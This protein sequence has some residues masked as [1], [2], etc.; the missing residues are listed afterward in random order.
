MLLN[1]F[2]PAKEAIVDQRFKDQLNDLNIIADSTANIQMTEYS[3]NQISYQYQA[4]T[5][6]LAVFSEVYYQPG[7]NAYIDGKPAKHFRANYVLRAMKLP[8]GNH[9]VEFKF[10]PKGYFVGE[11]ISLTSMILFFVVAIGAIVFG[12]KN[13]EKENE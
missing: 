3:P 13:L 12:I 10:E 7:W 1:G 2:D 8:V 9:K 5:E 4:K 6:Q 11:K